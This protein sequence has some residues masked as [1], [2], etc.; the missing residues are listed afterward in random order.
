MIFNRRF[1]KWQKSNCKVTVCNYFRKYSYV[2][3]FNLK[4]IYTFIPTLSR[5]ACGKD[6]PAFYR[7]ENVH[8]MSGCVYRLQMKLH[9][10]ALFNTEHTAH[11]YNLDIH[12]WTASILSHYFSKDRERQQD[13]CERVT[14]QPSW[15]VYPRWQC[16]V[17]IM[18]AH[19][20]RLKP[21]SLKL[22]MAWDN[23]PLIWFNCCLNI[24]RYLHIRGGLNMNTWFALILCL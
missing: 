19:N 23:T 15:F 6:P 4:Y 5:Q 18:V 21:I 12:T 8:L 9:H 17:V 16:F 3:H 14:W 20:S 22:M 1:I 13:N 7:M 11:L 2:L 24:F 10:L